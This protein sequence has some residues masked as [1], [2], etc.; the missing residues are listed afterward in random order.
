MTDKTTPIDSIT[1]EETRANI[2][3]AEL[4]PVLH[5]DDKAPIKVAFAGV[6]GKDASGT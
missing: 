5:P 1:H 3:S 6:E 4:E 2:P